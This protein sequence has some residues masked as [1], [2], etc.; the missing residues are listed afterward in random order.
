MHF[1]LFCLNTQRDKDKTPARIYGETL[2]Q[3]KV[4]DE[5]G[6]EIAWF[7]EH[8]FSNYCL[9]PSPM[10]MTTYMAGQTKRIKL[11]P[12][13]IVAPLYERIRLLEDIG[14]ADQL[15]GGRLVLG[16][17]TGY[18]EYEFHKFGVDLST[19]RAHLFETLDLLDTYLAGGEIEFD[20]KYTRLPP[21]H[22][23]VRTVQARPP[24]YV[25]GMGGDIE[26]QRRSVQRGYVP[27]F[28]TGWNSL[29]EIAA[30]RAKVV[31]TFV[32]AGG[33]ESAMSFATQRYVC[34][35]SDKSVA[36]KAAD[37]ARYIRRIAT[38]MRGKYGELD[39]SF[40]KET[41]AQGEPPLDEI[42]QRLLIGDADTVAERLRDEIA[43]LKLTHMSC[44]MA[45]PGVEQNDVLRSIR[46]FGEQ[47]IPRL[48][49][50]S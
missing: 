38:A 25:A 17:G 29:D 10:T 4:A 37:G 3:V 46:D 30:T 14:V 7:A 11:G 19:S 36:R 31:Q 26:L 50:Q 5:T 21:T 43:T 42:E 28:T 27:F 49:S 18:Q 6:F 34:I 13:V 1:G 2:D 15:S 33:T 44:F 45:I 40:L 41:P 20:G 23:S 8:H 47:V 22:F 16:F 12:A 39:G 35:T 24:I 9:C 48:Q 32:E